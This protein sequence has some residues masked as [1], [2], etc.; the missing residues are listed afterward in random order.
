MDDAALAVIVGAV[1]GLGSGALTGFVASRQFRAERFKEREKRFETAQTGYRHCYR[2]FLVN[3]AAVHGGGRGIPLDGQ[4]EVGLTTLV[5][6]FWEASFTGDP[7]VIRELEDYWPAAARKNGEP[8]DPSPPDALLEAMRLHGVR[9][10][11]DHQ[12]AQ[13]GFLQPR[14]PEGSEAAG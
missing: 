9:S 5:D 14:P 13:K 11:K 12:R 3:V 6:N 8:P 4:T 1:A 2:K 10:L 7:N